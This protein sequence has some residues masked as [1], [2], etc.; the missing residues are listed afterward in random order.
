MF[1]GALCEYMCVGCTDVD[2]SHVWGALCGDIQMCW[3]TWVGGNGDT[4][5]GANIHVSAHACGSQ[6][7]FG[8]SSSGLL[9]LLSA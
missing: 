4:Y 3:Y 6:G 5:V 2:S 7:S 9:H 8:S 1:G